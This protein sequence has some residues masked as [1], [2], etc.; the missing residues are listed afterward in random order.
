ME[1]TC[2][3]WNRVPETTSQF[4][5]PLLS[6]VGVGTIRAHMKVKNMLETRR[7]SATTMTI[8]LRHGSIILIGQSSLHPLLTASGCRGHVTAYQKQT[9]SRL[10]IHKDR[11]MRH[12]PSGK[13]NNYSWRQCC[14]L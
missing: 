2:G 12:I 8:H 14:R 1:L 13:R 6:Y 3:V 10:R 5:K 7:Q 4:H 11:Q 9:R